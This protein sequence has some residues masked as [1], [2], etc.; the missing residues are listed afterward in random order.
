MVL[1]ICLKARS[2]KQVKI[3]VEEA[4]A[5]MFVVDITTGVT[6]L[7]V[8]TAN[9]LRKTGK[10]VFM[11]ANKVDNHKLLEDISE[12]YSFGAGRDIWHIGY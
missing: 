9:M 12:F 5:I 11:V 7:D 1:M 4:D 10:P 2:V 6:D 8:T 3:A